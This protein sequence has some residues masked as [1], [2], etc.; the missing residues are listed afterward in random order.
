MKHVKFIILLLTTTYVVPGYHMVTSERSFDDAILKY[1]Y[2]LVCFVPSRPDDKTAS[3]DEKKE[4]K[5]DFRDVKKRMKSAATSG[6][7]KRYLKSKVGFVLVD[8]ATKRAQE[9]DDQYEL[10]KLPTCLLFKQGKPVFHGVHYAQIFEPIS[11]YSMLSLLEQYFDDDFQDLIKE[12]KEDEKQER[13]ERLARYQAYAR[14]GYPYGYGGWGYGY[15]Y[16]G[17]GYGYGGFGYGHRY[18]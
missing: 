3:R 11:K 2:A 13:Q 17:Y 9:V 18:W 16:W 10:D 14:Y 15:P 7:Y 6:K 12:K 8:V 5:E 1:P 4:L